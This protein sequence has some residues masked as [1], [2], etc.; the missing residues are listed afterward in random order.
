MSL[1]RP[2]SIYKHPQWIESLCS[3]SCLCWGRRT[4]RRCP[5]SDPWSRHVSS[6]KSE[7]LISNDHLNIEVHSKPASDA[8]SATHR[9]LLRKVYKLT[10]SSDTSD[11]W[12]PNAISVR[13]A[14]LRNPS[15]RRR[16]TSHCTGCENSTRL[17]S[18][19]H[20]LDA[21]THCSKMCHSTTMHRTLGQRPTH[22][23]PASGDTPVTSL[24][25]FSS[26]IENMHDR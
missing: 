23:P 14:Q 22:P 10:E 6:V 24:K 16:L 25:L 18:D 17:V 15:S 5:D 1:S 8:S 4:L 20:S 3:G 11:G 7:S 19:A 9:T 12:P 21:P 13:H 2:T 26:A